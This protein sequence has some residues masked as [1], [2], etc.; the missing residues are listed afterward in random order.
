MNLIYLLILAFVLAFFA[1]GAGLA[2]PLAIGLVLF[3]IAQMLK[4][5]FSYIF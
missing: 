1:A 2:G 3:C 4:K 5:L